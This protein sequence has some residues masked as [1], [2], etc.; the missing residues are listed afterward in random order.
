MREAIT[1]EKD[2][3]REMGRGWGWDEWGWEGGGEQGNSERKKRK[4]KHS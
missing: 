2:T 1:A 3:V 4:E